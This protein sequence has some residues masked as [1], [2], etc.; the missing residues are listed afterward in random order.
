MAGINVNLSYEG[1]WKMV[2]AIQN[3]ETPAEIRERCTIAK[4]WL[5]A[6]EVI[7]N[8]QFDD[9]MMAVTWLYREANRWERF[10]L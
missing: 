5:M 2:N 4:R 10:D 7:D 8:E 3:G 9:L 1:C 6:N